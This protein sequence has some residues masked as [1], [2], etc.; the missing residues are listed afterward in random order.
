MLNKRGGVG[1]HRVSTTK[2]R[3]Q[4][5]A[6]TSQYWAASTSMYGN[7]THPISSSIKL[8]PTIEAHVM[9]GMVKSPVA[10]HSIAILS[11]VDNDTSLLSAESSS[12]HQSL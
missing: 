12:M 9:P 1:R 6:T 4:T 11:G 8:E 7:M 10:D 3:V 2:Y 5:R